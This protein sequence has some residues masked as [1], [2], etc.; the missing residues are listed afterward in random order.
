[1]VNII[2]ENLCFI[3]LA[4]IFILYIANSQ[5]KNNQ[6][7]EDP[8]L[9]EWLEK[10]DIFYDQGRYGN[11]IKCYNKALELDPENVDAWVGKGYALNMLGRYLEAL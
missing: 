10:G 3:I 5:E 1:M 4:I 9:E 8:S 11:A 2:K 7:S 6:D